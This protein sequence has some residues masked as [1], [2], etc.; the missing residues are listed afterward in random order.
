MIT[1]FDERLKS[2]YEASPKELERREKVYDLHEK[3]DNIRNAWDSW[4][5]FN[6]GLHLL[7]PPQEIIEAWDKITPWLKE[8]GEDTLKDLEELEGI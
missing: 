1:L 2:Q 5:D 3:A 8:L 4:Q 7:D 6:K